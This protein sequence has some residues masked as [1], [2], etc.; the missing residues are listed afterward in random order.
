M[1]GQP[2]AITPA[3]DLGYITV[4]VPPAST[5]SSCSFD[6]TWP[7]TLGTML[8]L[9]ALVLGVFLLGASEATMSRVSARR[10]GLGGGSC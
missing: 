10:H 3:G 2:V 4:P 7:R 1:D 8:S 6:D 9:S 5:P